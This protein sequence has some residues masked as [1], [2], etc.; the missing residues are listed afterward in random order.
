MSVTYRDAGPGDAGALAA[1]FRDIFIATFGHLYAPDDLAAFLAGH[2]EDRWREELAD[3][4]IAVRLAE[5][6]GVP[7]GY[8]QLTALRLP[9]ETAAPAA[10]I[11][12]LYVGAKWHG[13]GVA[14]ALMDWALGEARRRGT[15]ELYLS[16]FIDNQRARRFY[17]RYGFTV[18]GPYAF[19]VGKQAD[20]DVILRLAL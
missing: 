15:R 3:P 7:A 18:H 11:G 1:Q 6:D 5:D 12:Q 2:G 4:G 13:G 20:E 16:V 8:L 10:E 17:A 19:M 9:V 14:A